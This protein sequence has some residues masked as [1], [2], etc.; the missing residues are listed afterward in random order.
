MIIED[1]FHSPKN[2]ETKYIESLK[3]YLR[4]FEKIFFI[5]CNHINKYSPDWN[6]DKLLVLKKS[7]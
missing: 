4:L 5:E 2:L 6:N 1:I 3:N 7:D